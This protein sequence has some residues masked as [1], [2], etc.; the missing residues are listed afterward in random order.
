M[1]TTKGELYIKSS[2]VDQNDLHCARSTAGL[3]RTPRQVTK[4][5]GVRH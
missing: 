1:C 2:G 4:R 5:L 3:M